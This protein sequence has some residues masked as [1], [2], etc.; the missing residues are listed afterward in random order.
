MLNAVKEIKKVGKETYDQIYKKSLIGIW[1]CIIAFWIAFIVLSIISFMDSSCLWV[2]I[3][4]FIFGLLGTVDMT[5]SKL[6]LL[7]KYAAKCANQK[8][9]DHMDA[10]RDEYER[11]LGFNLP[12]ELE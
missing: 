6:N 2:A 11:I 10:K 8:A 9:A 4:L 5:I 1:C 12:D 7:K 3:S